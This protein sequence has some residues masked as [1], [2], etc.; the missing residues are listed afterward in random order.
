M[1]RKSLARMGDPYN[2]IILVLDLVSAHS[3]TSEELD[4]LIAEEKSARG[5]QA[6]YHSGVEDVLYFCWRQLEVIKLEDNRFELTQAGERLHQYLYTPAFPEDLFQLLIQTSTERFTYFYQV[7]SA[8][9]RYV[10]QGVTTIPQSELRAL[11]DE[12]NRVSKKE[13]KRLMIDCTAIEIKEDAVSLN[14]RL[15]GVD[16]LEVQI[17]QLLNSIETMMQEEGRLVY[18][19]TIERLWELHPAIDIRQLE[20]ALRSR[21]WLNATRTV[22]Y[23]D[24]IR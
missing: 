4:K 18:S 16:P 10:R 14:P 12:T 11:L 1:A 13:I 9:N 24:G 21:L 22:E 15:L 5:I 3:P 8:L 17:T 23:I 2:G 20:P 7:Y 6:E 19:G